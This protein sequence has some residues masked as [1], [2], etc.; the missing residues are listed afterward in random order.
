[1]T[2]T[3][4]NCSAREIVVVS[5]SDDGY[6]MPLAVTIR[7]ALNHLG[8]D[9]RMQLF[10]LD[11]GLTEESKTRLLKSWIDP[12]LTVEWIRPNMDLVRDLY[13]SYQV[14]TVTYL[15]LL[16]AELLPEYV[17]RA[18]YLD[19]DMLVRRDLGDL[20]DEPQHGLAILA[21]PEIAAPY[22]DAAASMPN[23]ENCRKHLC[24]FTPIAN[25]RELGLPSDAQY[26]NGG[27]L[28][29]DIAQWRREN[30]AKQMLDCLRQNCEHVLWWDQYAL[31]VVLARR[32]R[33]LDYRW[34][35]GTHLFAYPNWR[36]CPLDRATYEQLRKSPWIVHFSSPSK[37][38]H[39]FCR[40]P[41][42]R[43]FFRCLEQTQWRGWRPERPDHLIKQWWDFHYRPLRNQWKSRIRA[44][45]QSVR[46]KRRKA[47]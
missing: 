25:Y 42:R 24:A 13:V 28:V 34:N 47:A 5:A 21:V 26:F 2:S 33:P 12:R 40:H 36:K 30:F 44:L 18:L 38:W 43:E 41:F 20:W 35:Q 15:R 3:S 23:F 19:A 7:S 29:A 22:I 1:M 37:P 17:T 10:L 11:G 46:R 6:A 4:S 27:L 16:M 32:W 45:K 31:N 8:A 9:R 39:Y 14:T